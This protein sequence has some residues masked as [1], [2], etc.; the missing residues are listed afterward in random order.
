MFYKYV[1]I[2][3]CVAEWSEKLSLLTQHKRDKQRIYKSRTGKISSDFRDSRSVCHG[4]EWR[5]LDEA[6][7]VAPSSST[8][9]QVKK[10]KW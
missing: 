10:D 9:C 2:L 4:T 1:R 5:I 7:V 8:Y 3:V 6:N